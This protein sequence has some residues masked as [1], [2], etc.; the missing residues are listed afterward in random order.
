[1]SKSLKPWRRYV[2]FRFFNMAAAAIWDLKNFNF[3]TI[4]AVKRVELRHHAKFRRIRPNRGPYM[5]IFRF[6]KMAVAAI[7]DFRNFKF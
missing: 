3:F 1:M 5:V 7:M 6:F 2:S 4:D